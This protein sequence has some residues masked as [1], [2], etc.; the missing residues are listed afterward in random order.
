MEPAPCG[1]WLVTDPDLRNVTMIGYCRCTRGMLAA[2]AF[3]YFLVVTDEDV[4][5][6]TLSADAGLYRD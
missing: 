4:R 6:N 1:R 2:L 3:C 5:F